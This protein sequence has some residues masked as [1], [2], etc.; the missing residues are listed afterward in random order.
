MNAMAPMQ[1]ERTEEFVKSEV[2]A[3]NAAWQLTG[4]CFKLGIKDKTALILSVSQSGQVTKIWSNKEHA[5]STCLKAIVSA[6]VFPV[7]PYQPYY[8]KVSM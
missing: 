5:K 6:S 8:I 7:P 3:I 4:P 2:E 1:D